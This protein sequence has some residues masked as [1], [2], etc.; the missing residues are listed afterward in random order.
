MQSKPNSPFFCER[1][2][3][4]YV[5]PGDCVD[6]TEEGLLDLR[7]PEVLHLLD[8]LDTHHF[9]KRVAM[10][11]LISAI[12]FLP[13]AALFIVLSPGRGWWWGGWWYGMA[14]VV[15]SRGLTWALP[16]KKKRPELPDYSLRICL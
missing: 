14:V 8:T 11:S 3:K 10:Y 7:D 6:C 12:V 1:C 4:R 16:P 2:E 9:R 15:L 13:F 5:D